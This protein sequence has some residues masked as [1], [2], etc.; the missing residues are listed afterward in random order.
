MRILTLGDSWTFGSESSDPTRMSWPAQMSAK[1][2]VD[3]V[4][5]ARGG[6]SNQRAVRI[7]IEEL[8]RDSRYD[9]VILA[10]GPASRTEILK[11]GKW[12]QIWPHRGS[13]TLDKIYADFWHPW[14]DLQ[15][16]ML[17]TIQ[18]ICT[19]E[20]LGPKLFVTGLSMFPD[21]YHEQMSWILT[22]KNDNDFRS[23][24]MPLEIFNIGIK[25]LDRKLRSLKAI[26]TEILKR[27]PQYLFDVPKNYLL[28]DMVRQKYG[29]KIFSSGGHPNDKGY[30]ALCDYFADKIGLRR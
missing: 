29:S 14:N 9:W 18:F 27:Q 22:Y 8:C 12:H 25:D 26:H 10:L 30:E 7:G 15:Q 20:N 28:S 5:L 6:S 23:L 11:L 24:D 2:N 4:N 21:Q 13:D 17:L 1:Y 3:V 19:V 16:I